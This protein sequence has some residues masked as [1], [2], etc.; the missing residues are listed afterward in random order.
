MDDKNKKVISSAFGLVNHSEIS[1]TDLKI[2][3]LQKD[4]K[5]SAI[6]LQ[7]KEE[8]IKSLN[9]VIKEKNYEIDRANKEMDRL[10]KVIQNYQKL[11]LLMF[12]DP[13]KDKGESDAE[14]VSEEV[15]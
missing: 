15:S 4:L 1:E 11:T 3:K 10:H 2:E 7:A 9:H 5:A 12:I 13:D 8:V 6:M 14:Q